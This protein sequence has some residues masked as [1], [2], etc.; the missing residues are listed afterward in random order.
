MADHLKS[1][2]LEEFPQCPYCNSNE[3]V[4]KLS[5][6]L[7]VMVRLFIFKPLDTHYC[8]KCETAF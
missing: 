1:E 8:T 3:D 2:N 7:H 5:E 4:V 6:N